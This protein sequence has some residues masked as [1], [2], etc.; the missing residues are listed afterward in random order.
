MEISTHIILFGG[1]IVISLITYKSIQFYTRLR[2]IT[3]VGEEEK[4]IRLL[5]RE[6]HKSDQEI[7][8]LIS[9]LTYDPSNTEALQRFRPIINNTHCIFAKSSKLW[10]NDGWQPDKSLE[11]NVL[12]SVL[13]L[14]IFLKY[15]R[16]ST[17]LTLIE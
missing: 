1:A 3:E 7:Q 16:K 13:P 11:E 5:K 12:R 2:K 10:T 9:K 17:D 6:L 4:P 8:K 14:S 15:L